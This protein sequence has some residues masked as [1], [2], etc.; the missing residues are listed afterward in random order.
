MP[1]MMENF[2]FGSFAGNGTVRGIRKFRYGWWSLTH[3]DD[4]VLSCICLCLHWFIYSS[5]YSS[6]KL[7]KCMMN[8]PQAPGY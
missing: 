8:I 3:N 1:D 5:T 2:N 6:S 7:T 4:V